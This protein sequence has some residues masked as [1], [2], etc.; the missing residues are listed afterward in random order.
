MYHHLLY[1]VEL[2][3]CYVLLYVPGL[4]SSYCWVFNFLTPWY[5]YASDKLPDFPPKSV[6]LKR[7]FGVQP[8]AD[9]EESVGNLLMVR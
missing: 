7:P 4:T 3:F 9:S 8:W 1:E 6:L 2:S 5:T